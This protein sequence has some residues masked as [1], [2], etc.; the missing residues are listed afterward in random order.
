[1]KFIISAAINP[2]NTPKNNKPVL[3]NKKLN[4]NIAD[5]NRDE[6]VNTKDVVLIRRSISGL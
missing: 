6:K 2:K 1:M 3:T 4:T 5:Y